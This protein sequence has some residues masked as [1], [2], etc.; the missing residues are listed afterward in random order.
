MQL[1]TLHMIMFFF[2]FDLFNTKPTM[3]TRILAKTPLWPNFVCIWPLKCNKLQKI[4]PYDI[5][6][7]ALYTEKIFFW[8][9]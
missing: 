6:E 9:Y 3:F 2:L 5:H 1:V 8:I 7:A 4:T